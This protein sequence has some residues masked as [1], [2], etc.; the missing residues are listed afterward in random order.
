MSDFVRV[1]VLGDVPMGTAL[2]VTVN[3]RAI[4]LVNCAEGVF[5]ISDV[6]SHADVSLSE[7]E[8][9]DCTIE[10]WLHGSQFNLRTGLPLT[11]PAISAVPTYEVRLVDD[12][13]TTHIEVAT[14]PTPVST[15]GRPQS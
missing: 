13:G 12:A 8:V 1:A 14:S 5:A 4:A 9:I 15:D 2:K 10:C 3:N 7:G 11:P 6:C